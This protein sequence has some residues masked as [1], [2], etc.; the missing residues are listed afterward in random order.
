MSEQTPTIRQLI[1]DVKKDASHLLATQKELAS[2]EGSQDGKQVGM[3]AGMFGAAAA[4]GALGGI[5]LL[6]TLAY[7]LVALGLPTWAGF[8][9]VTLLLFVAA[10]ITALIGR[11]ASKKINGMKTTKAELQAN[12][13][14]LTGK[15]PSSEVAISPATA[16]AKK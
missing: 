16:P 11:G 14:A 6:V 1:A 12:K 9:I 15:S 3:T 10:G 5:F 13:A 7:V 2:V 8:G 4:A